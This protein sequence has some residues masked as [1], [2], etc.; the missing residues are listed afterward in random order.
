MAIGANAKVTSTIIIDSEPRVPLS[1]TQLI[2]PNGETVDLDC[3]RPDIPNDGLEV[4]LYSAFYIL[5]FDPNVPAEQ[6]SCLNT[7]VGDDVRKICAA[8]TS[9]SIKA[10]DASKEP[11][12]KNRL[13]RIRFICKSP[14]HRASMLS[15]LI[16]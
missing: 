2:I 5:S 8:Q 6:G 15:S 16:E 11:G 3:P 9:C 1:V 10:Q 14:R 7:N 13:L 4:F 12:C